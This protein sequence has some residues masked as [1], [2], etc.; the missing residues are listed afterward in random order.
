MPAQTIDHIDQQYT[1]KLYSIYAN[2]LDAAVLTTQDWQF[3][4]DLKN[5]PDLNEEWRDMAHRVS[6]LVRKGRIRVV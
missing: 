4:A 6:Y 5:V 3:I 2:S 1:E